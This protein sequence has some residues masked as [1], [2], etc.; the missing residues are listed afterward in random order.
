MD[1]LAQNMVALLV[2]AAEV[3][4]PITDSAHAVTDMMRTA[5][6]HAPAANRPDVAEVFDALG[7][8]VAAADRYAAAER[9]T[10]AALAALPEHPDVYPVLGAFLDAASPALPHHGPR[11]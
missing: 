10:G 2:T 8:W 4:A 9:R 3:L 6:G 7:A 5:A 11:T 1:A